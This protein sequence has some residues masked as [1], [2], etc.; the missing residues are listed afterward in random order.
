[1]ISKKWLQA[2]GVAGVLVMALAACGDDDGDDANP[3]AE[4]TTEAS[5]ESMEE[6]SGT[7]TIDG[8]S[9]VAPYSEAAAELFMGEHSG[10]Q[11]SVGT[12]GTG[13]GFERFCAGETDISDASRPISDDEI[14]LC[15]GAGIEW[16]EVNVANDALSVLVHPENPVECLTVEQ[17]NAIWAPDS[18]I[19]N[20]SEIPD[21]DVDFDAP[22][23]LYGPGSTSG[24]FDY[25]TEAIN[26]EE[27]ATRTDYNDIG[28]D[29][30]AG[31]VG[32]EGTV[33][34]MFY[35]GF[36]YYVENQDRIKALQIDGGGGCV[37]PAAETVQDGSYAPLGR[38]LYVYPKAEALER[39][40]VLE[41]LTFYIQSNESIV[42][43][44][45]GIP[46]TEEQKSESQAKID[47]LIGG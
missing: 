36:T 22:L 1:V 13:G 33:G 14:A 15:E 19:S 32:V 16:E 8:S 6:L 43:P 39:P 34:G 9:T 7:I 5:D 27:G 12:S 25:F 30:N 20:W 26:G 4:E 45:G 46:L 23:D 28:E 17:L 10:V 38:Q 21:L 3:N 24:T 37:E 47:S 42:E 18:T 2:T 29:D 40:E 11:I 41:F 44:V 35:V 31:L